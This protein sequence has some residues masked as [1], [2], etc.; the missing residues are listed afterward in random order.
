[1]T[2]EERRKGNILTKYTVDADD[3]CTAAVV[4]ILPERNFPSVIRPPEY[5]TAREK[6]SNQRMI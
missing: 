3:H 2:A 5:K 4:V 6:L 1:M